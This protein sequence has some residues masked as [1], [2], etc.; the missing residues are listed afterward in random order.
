MD[1]AGNYFHFWALCF[2]LSSSSVGGAYGDDGWLLLLPGKHK[3]GVKWL[4]NRDKGEG[5]N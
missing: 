1:D 5:I 4:G 2:S 3:T